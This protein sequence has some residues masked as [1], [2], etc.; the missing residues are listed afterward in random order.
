MS[1]ISGE[2]VRAKLLGRA[3]NG[4][5]RWTDVALTALVATIVVAVW[6]SAQPGLS[7]S[8]DERARSL[9]AEL[10]CPVCQGLSI[11]DSP[12]PLAEEM[13]RIV[14]EELA[15][16]AS[17]QDVRDFFV[18]RYGPWILLSPPIRGPDVLLWLAPGGFLLLGLL[19]LV[20][21]R[22]RRA[23]HRAG[24]RT[25]RLGRLGSVALGIGILGGL[26][27]PLALAVGGRIAGQQIT[28]FFPGGGS[29][30][31]AD[32][33]ARVA[34]RPT[35]PTTL[36][37]LADAY[38]A[39]GRLD[40]AG[41]LYRRVLEQ[42]PDNVPALIG[43]GVILIVADRPDAAVIA[44]DSAIAVAPD[45]PDALIYRALARARLEGAG[46]AAVRA[47]AGRF[48]AVAPDDPRAD[49]ARRLLASPTIAAPSTGP[50]PPTP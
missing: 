38:T 47:D 50:V 4:A 15:T 43:V 26:A 17:D 44:L 34:A 33:E 1:P 28:G 14:R 25:R 2:A 21:R 31:L 12:A 41:A 39:A 19:A 10:R 11:A 5:S 7:R 3:T 37:A 20:A 13:R 42:D 36:V 16:G 46:S 30:S 40:E 35:D 48:L 23:S 45:D 8:L 29:P 6:L 22:R 32:L 27:V 9:A 18:A 24:A 49:M